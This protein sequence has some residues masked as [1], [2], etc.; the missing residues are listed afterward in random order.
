MRRAPATT[1]RVQPADHVVRRDSERVAARV[2][3]LDDGRTVN[4]S[5][6]KFIGIAIRI[7][8]SVEFPAGFGEHLHVEARYVVSTAIRLRGRVPMDR[9]EM[10]RTEIDRHGTMRTQPLREAITR[11]AA[12]GFL[13]GG[14]VRLALGGAIDLHPPMLWALYLPFGAIAA[15]VAA[16]IVV[17]LIALPVLCRFAPGDRLPDAVYR[18]AGTLSAVA[19][20]VG[21]LV[22]VPPTGS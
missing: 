16:G 18:A 19:A 13:S 9:I 20:F 14:V 8:P 22:G 17:N 21:G 2:D 4:H 7:Q 1:T 5:A 10:Q 3:R 11:A 6:R 15:A 12:V